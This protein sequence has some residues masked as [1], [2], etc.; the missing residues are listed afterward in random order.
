MLESF[1]NSTTSEKRGRRSGC[2]RLMSAISLKFFFF[3]LG[4]PLGWRLSGCLLSF[5]ES[6]PNCDTILRPF[7]FAVSLEKAATWTGHDD[8]VL[9]TFLNLFILLQPDSAV[10]TQ[11]RLQILAQT[12]N[13]LIWLL[14]S[15]N[16]HSIHEQ[17]INSAMRSHKTANT[18]VCVCVCRGLLL[19]RFLIKS[20]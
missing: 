3:L 2:F 8:Y 19:F 14:T 20:R 4:N 11:N 17:A 13:I 1:I 7:A 10:M 6:T 15:L 9:F 18:G 12:G 16:P 5:R